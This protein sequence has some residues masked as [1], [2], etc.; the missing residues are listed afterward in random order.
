MDRSD[1]AT[2]GGM[3]ERDGRVRTGRGIDFAEL[4]QS[5]AEATTVVEVLRH[6]VEAGVRIVR[7]ADVVSVTFREPDGTYSTP[8]ETGV[9]ASRLDRLQYDLG[10]GPCVA[11]TERHRPGIVM[12]PDVSVDAALAP[13]GEA[14]AREGVWSALAVGLCPVE[15]P[16]R[17]GALNF[18]SFRRH[19]LDEADQEVAVILAAH[20]HVALN[21]TRA[22]T[23]AE[24][25]SAQLRNALATRDVIGQAKGI[26]MERQGITE[27]EAFALLRSA[28]QGMNIKLAQLAGELVTRRLRL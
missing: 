26:L 11:A 3:P 20:A 9:I 4:S 21:A 22:V 6:V 14:A 1:Q 18:Y 17:S 15:D 5:L 23:A 27:D 25:Q 19:G 28:S 24:L 7:G 16:P 12:S 10:R 2:N 8:V 13:W